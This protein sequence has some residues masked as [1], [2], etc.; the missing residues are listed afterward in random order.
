L[1]VLTFPVEPRFEPVEH[2]F[3]HIKRGFEPVECKFEYIKREFR[4]S[5]S[6]NTRRRSVRERS[7]AASGDMVIGVEDRRA[8]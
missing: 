3:E 7:H 1:F 4:P 5:F 8:L 6:L 2:E